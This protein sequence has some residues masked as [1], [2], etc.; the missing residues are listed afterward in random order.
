M[1]ACSSRGVEAARRSSRRCWCRA[2]RRRTGPARPAASATRRAPA[3]G[4]GSFAHPHRIRRRPRESSPCYGL[5]RSSSGRNRHVS[6]GILEGKTALVAGVANKRSIAWAIAQALHGAGAQLAFTYQG[7]RLEDSVRKLADERRQPT[8]WCPATCPTTPASTQ[9]FEPVGRGTGRARHPGALDRLRARRRVRE[10][11][12]RDLAGGVCDLARHLGVLDDRDGAA[13][14]AADERRG[15][16]AMVTLTYMAS[17]RAFPGYNVMAVAKAALECSV[18]Y[19]AYELGAGADPRQRDLGRAGAHAGRQGH[20][21]LRPDG[22]RD[23]AALAARR[24]T[25]R[26]P[27]SAAPPCTSAARLAAMVTGTTLYVDSGYHAMGM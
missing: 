2:G 11:L 1:T 23:R 3:S 15:G 5:P 9:A 12:H 19:L 13:G 26:P 17:E 10:S 21:R 25:S 16:G 22:E 24:R 14:R 20:P 7:E 18:R 8:W 6:E 4:C 27:T